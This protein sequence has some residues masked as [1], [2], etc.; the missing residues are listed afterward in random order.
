[1]NILREDQVA[2]SVYF[3]GY[4]RGSATP[5]FRFSPWEGGARLHGA[6]A[7]VACGVHELVESG[8]HQI[9]IGDVQSFYVG[10]GGRPLVY[11]QSRY[12]HL[13]EE[14]VRPDKKARTTG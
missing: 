1:V 11:A 4:W 8:D 9:V 10:A 13:G 3:S 14:I 6:I 12:H 2:L 7:S 5:V